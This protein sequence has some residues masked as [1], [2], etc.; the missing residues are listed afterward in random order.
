MGSEISSE[1]PDYSPPASPTPTETS[2]DLLQILQEIKKGIAIIENKINALT[3][4]ITTMDTK[5]SKITERMEHH[6]ERRIGDAED[7]IGT[8]ERKMEAIQNELSHLKG[9]CDDQEN[10]VHR[11]NIHLMGLPEGAEGNDPQKFLEKWLPQLL[12]LQDLLKALEIECMHWALKP[13]PGPQDRLTILIFKML[14]FPDKELIVQQA[15]ESLSI[16]KN[17]RIYLFPDLSTDLY[18]RRKDFDEAKSICRA[19]SIPFALLY[20][21]KLMLTP[22]GHENVC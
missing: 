4:K 19:R 1:R 14:R 18:R 2:T 8:I 10:R 3:S 22:S 6:A 11:S 9:K 5:M 7:A 17:H 16:K 21:T 15:R 13:H 12:Q 20:L